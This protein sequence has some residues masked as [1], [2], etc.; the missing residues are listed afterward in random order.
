ML[1]NTKVNFCIYKDSNSLESFILETF[2]MSKSALKKFKLKK[3]FL[4]KSLRSKDEIDLDINIINYGRIK[5]H[6]SF[7]S[8]LC[9]KEDEQIL[10]VSKSYKTHSYPLTYN[11]TNN[12][13]SNLFYYRPKLSEVNEDSMDRGLL[14]RL[15]FETSGVMLYAKNNTIYKKIRDNFKGLVH[16]KEYLAIVQGKISDNVELHH[17]IIAKKKKMQVSSEETSSEANLRV[18]RVDY[19]QEEDLS[20]VRVF[21]NQGHR[22]QIRVQLSYIGHPI[23]GDELYGAKKEQR[24]YLHCLRYKLNDQEFVDRDAQLFN[25]FFDLYGE[26]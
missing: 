3:N 23:L 16:H 25:L 8:E 26:L 20:L 6:N 22:H 1:S 15:D 13:L 24:L 12:V 4:N 18:H 2:L 19:N 9:L 14:Y 17:Y 10:A 5:H 21:L 11:E 7:T